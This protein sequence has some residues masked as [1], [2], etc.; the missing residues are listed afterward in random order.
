LAETFFISAT[1]FGDH[2][3]NKDQIK[4]TA[5]HAAGKVQEQVGKMTGNRSQEAKG[6][7]REAAGKVQ[8]GY[9]DAKQNIKDATK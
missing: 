2:I 7:G 4:G 6:V 9:G 5:K 3:M 1:K 8:K